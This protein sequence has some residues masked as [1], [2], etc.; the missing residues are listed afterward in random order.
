MWKEKKIR[1]KKAKNYKFEKN[2]TSMTALF[3][4]GVPSLKNQRLLCTC[5][6]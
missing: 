5:H 1:Y 2:L 6:S 4:M 3:Y